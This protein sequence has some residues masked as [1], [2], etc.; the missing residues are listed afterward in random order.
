MALC[1]DKHGSRVVDVVW[2]QSEIS[3]K[4]ELAEILLTNEEELMGDFYGQIVL[5]NCNISHYKKKQASWQEQQRVMEKKRHL[6]EDIIT[7][8][9]HPALKKVKLT[10][11][12]AS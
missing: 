10:G 4:E 12:T 6:F 2:R 7:E 9:E 1:K 11:Q 3:K 5:R 8:E